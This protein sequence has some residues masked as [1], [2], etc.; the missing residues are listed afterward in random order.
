MEVEVEEF[1]GQLSLK[2]LE[3][4][5]IVMEVIPLEKVISKGQEPHVG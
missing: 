5:D 3:K 2:D 4:E 1:C